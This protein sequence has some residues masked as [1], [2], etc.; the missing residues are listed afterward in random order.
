[1]STSAVQQTN[2]FAHEYSM[3]IY[4]CQKQQSQK[5]Q[6][7]QLTAASGTATIGR[8]NVQMRRMQRAIA[9]I[10]SR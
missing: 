10:N 8:Y 3:E 7:M 1:M 6:M 5:Q 9:G 4:Y 2:Q